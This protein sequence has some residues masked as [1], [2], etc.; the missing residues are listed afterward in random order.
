MSRKHLEEASSPWPRWGRGGHRALQP[1]LLPL[2]QGLCVLPSPTLGQEG[3]GHWQGCVLR[4]WVPAWPV[5][6]RGNFSS[7]LTPGGSSA[8]LAGVSRKPLACPR[9]PVLPLSHPS[10]AAAWAFH[11]HGHT[12]GAEPTGAREGA[13]LPCG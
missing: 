11:R 7:I 10:W 6:L 3:L 4:L 2:T 5:A 8:S 12:W 9:L 1:S 13:R